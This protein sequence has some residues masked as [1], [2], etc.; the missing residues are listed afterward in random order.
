MIHSKEG[1]TQGDC[2]AISLYIIAMLPLAMQMW[3]VVPHTL[4][5]WHHADIAG[6]AGDA[7][8]NA[9]CLQ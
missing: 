4:Q 7:Q 9:A 3:E 5:P 8:W 6:A 2:F 1:I